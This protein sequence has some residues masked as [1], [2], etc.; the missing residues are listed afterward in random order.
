MSWKVQYNQDTEVVELIN[1]GVFTPEDLFEE[2][3]AAYSLGLEKGTR[4]F[5]VDGSKRTQLAVSMTDYY[6]VMSM[7]REM[8]E[9]YGCT[10]ALVLPASQ[11]ADDGMRFFETASSN[12][13]YR[14]KTF[15]T[16]A[17]AEEW[18][19]SDGHD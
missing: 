7:L 13:G 19:S 5:M 14:V 12:I 15:T 17:E 9:I 16:R 6:Q 8:P 3:P 1:E 11:T 10:L 18:L 4:K 2:V